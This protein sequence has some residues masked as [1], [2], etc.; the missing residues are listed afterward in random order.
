MFSCQS[1]P[2][3]VVKMLGGYTAGGVGGEDAAEEASGLIVAH[4]FLASFSP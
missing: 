2:Y 3:R 4:F 1:L